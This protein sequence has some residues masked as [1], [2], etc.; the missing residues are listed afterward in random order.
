ML[1][2]SVD[3]RH[4]RVALVVPLR[5]MQV[6]RVPAFED[7]VP[8][9]LVPEELGVKIVHTELREVRHVVTDLP[10]EVGMGHLLDA[11]HISTEVLVRVPPVLNCILVNPEVCGS[12]SLSKSGLEIA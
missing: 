11:V 2:R 1:W 7:V 6:P 3:D 4:T 12:S 9:K 10:S 8:L 5:R